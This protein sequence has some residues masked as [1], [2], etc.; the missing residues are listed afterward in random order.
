MSLP[1]VS[2]IGISHFGRSHIIEVID[3]QRCM[4][5]LEMSKG[6]IIEAPVHELLA[7]FMDDFIAPTW[8]DMV[9]AID[10][11][12]L[13][14]NPPTVENKTNCLNL[15]TFEC[16]AYTI[17]ELNRDHGV[18]LLM[19]A[20]HRGNIL[21]MKALLERG[22][23]VNTVSTINRGALEYVV[24]GVYPDAHAVECIELLTSNGAR[25]R[26]TASALVA[27]RSDDRDRIAQALMNV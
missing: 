3:E 10:R 23:N 5:R 25:C 27:Q 7:R 24:L 8:G 1:T 21:V 12:D 19:M 17:N 6:T 9:I 4:G 2:H 26:A 11:Y 13:V 16:G 22:A 20:A 14:F 15:I 18:T